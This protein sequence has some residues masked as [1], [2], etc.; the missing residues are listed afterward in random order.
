MTGTIFANYIP[1]L[2]KVLNYYLN[3]SKRHRR[4]VN[5]E[6]AE[7]VNDTFVLSLKPAEIRL[8]FKAVFK[9]A[10]EL[11]RPYQSSVTTVTKSVLKC[12]LQSTQPPNPQAPK[13]QATRFCP[14]HNIVE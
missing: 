4:I 5:L 12:I 7:A 13:A 2:T 3:I 6:I 1:Y 14:S 8:H 9:A 10:F 11:G